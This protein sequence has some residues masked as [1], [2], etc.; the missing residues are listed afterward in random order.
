[1]AALFGHTF[2]RVSVHS[3]AWLIRN[4]TACTL[5]SG[6]VG[7]ARERKIKGLSI[8]GCYGG[9]QKCSQLHSQKEKGRVKI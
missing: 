4:I 6:L 5:K 9:A 2:L 3:N 7:G 1:M 8:P